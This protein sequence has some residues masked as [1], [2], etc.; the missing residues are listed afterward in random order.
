MCLPPLVCG[1]LSGQCDFGDDEQVESVKFFYTFGIIMAKRHFI[2]LKDL[3][4]NN[5]IDIFAHEWK[6]GIILLEKKIS[7]FP[8]YAL[9]LIRFL[10]DD[11]AS[12][13]WAIRDKANCGGQMI[14]V[15]NTNYHF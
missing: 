3:I 5:R 2:W 11:N 8:F 4:W 12:L 9:C 10:L 15:K 13:S 6:K 1:H 14:L 7:V